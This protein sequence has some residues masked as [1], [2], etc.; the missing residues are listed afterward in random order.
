MAEQ[1]L[2]IVVEAV[3]NASAQ[4]KQIGKDLG[5]MTG[6]VNEQDEASKKAAFGFD[7]LTKAIFKGNIM[8]TI[9]KKSFEKLA[10]IRKTLD[11]KEIKN[12]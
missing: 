11:L 12:D 10:Q 1:D 8:A 5:K 7:F 4:L 3:N 2:Q 6:A 9:A